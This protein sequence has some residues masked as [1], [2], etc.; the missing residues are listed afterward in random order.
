MRRENVPVER[1]FL[2]VGD[3]LD[4]LPEMFLQPVANSTPH[5]PQKT[6]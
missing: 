2:S 3:A 6:A 5:I 4:A 1:T